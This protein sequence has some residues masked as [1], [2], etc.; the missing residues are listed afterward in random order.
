VRVAIVG[1]G[2]LGC[3]FGAL[4]SRAGNDVTLIARPAHVDVLREQGLVLRSSVHGEIA[5]PVNVS[6]T[7]EEVGVVDLVLMCVKTY[8]LHTAAEQAK[9]LVGQDTVVLPVQNGVESA[10][11]L[12]AILNAGRVLGGTTVVNAHREAPGVVRHS[13]GQQLNLGELPGGL[14]ARTA[15]LTEAFQRAGIAAQA[16]ANITMLIWEKFAGICGAAVSALVRLPV[17]PVL[18][19]PPTRD[20]VAQTA[21]EVVSVARALGVML[22]ADYGDQVVARLG[23]YPEWAKPS[24]LVDLEQ[25]HRLELDALT[26]AVVRLGRQ[27]AVNTPA[28]SAVYA[29]LAPYIDGAPS[30]PTPSE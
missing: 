13:G 2:G 19:C 21:G 6:A 22:D 7:V 16:Q 10:E 27:Q 11:L 14:S 23:A 28:N 29:A 20:F 8:D 4:L 12:G 1:A 9:P 5:A 17:G 26:G 15:R 3:Y 30:I 18:S 24:L 25:G